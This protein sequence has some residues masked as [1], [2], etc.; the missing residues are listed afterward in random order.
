MRAGAKQF[1]SINSLNVLFSKHD[2]ETYLAD[3]SQEEDV[4]HI[5]VA[6]G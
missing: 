1:P 4:L 3:F 6:V 5:I 2:I